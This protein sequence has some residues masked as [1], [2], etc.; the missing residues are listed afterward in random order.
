MKT[1]K[2]L[3]CWFTKHWKDISDSY[4]WCNVNKELT[5]EE[6]DKVVDYFSKKEN[7]NFVI[8]L[9]G[10]NE[11]RPQRTW[12]DLPEWFRN[13][14]E[15]HDIYH[16]NNTF[17]F[18]SCIEDDNKTT[19]MNNALELAFE[20]TCNDYLSGI[21]DFKINL[22]KSKA[23]NSYYLPPFFPMWDMCHCCADC[24]K[25]CAR[26]KPSEERICTV[27]DF[28]NVCVEYEKKI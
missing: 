28:S 6:I 10:I 8:I 19:L 1:V 12:G 9:S 15:Y 2:G 22:E 24:A 27:S 26:K 14:T 16:A 21:K 11:L 23:D 25:D 13:N 20:A 3:L 5:K 17:V 4:G 18:A 7:I